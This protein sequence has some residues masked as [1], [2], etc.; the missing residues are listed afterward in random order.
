MSYLPVALNQMEKDA[1]N[2][3]KDS[4]KAENVS[5]WKV[6]NRQVRFTLS[7]KCF[8]S[9]KHL[10]FISHILLQVLEAV[11]E[12]RE[13]VEGEKEIRQRQIVEGSRI[14]AKKLEAEDRK[15]LVK[16]CDDVD[17]FTKSMTQLRKKA[18]VNDCI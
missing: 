3:E 17:E 7:Q 12:V 2:L 14:L 11:T 10:Q 4:K 5:I 6:S 18:Q 8:T 13:A 1:K 9:S 15:L 16:M